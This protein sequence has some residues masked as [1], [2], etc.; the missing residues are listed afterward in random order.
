MSSK[1]ISGRS[2]LPRSATCGA[3]PQGHITPLRHPFIGPVLG[4][5]AA[6]V[7]FAAVMALGAS[8]GSAAG[9]WDVDRDAL[10][11]VH[12]KEMVLPAPLAEGIRGM[13]SGQGT[14][15]GPAQKGSQSSYFK[16]WTEPTLRGCSRSTGP[17]STVRSNLG[18]GPTG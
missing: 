1:E 13:I 16:R 11:M 14:V 8:V 3:L 2:L 17:R 9:G 18:A 7:V 5:I 12:A 10:G 15:G 4:A 6:A